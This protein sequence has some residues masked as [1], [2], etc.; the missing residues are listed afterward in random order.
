MGEFFTSSHG[1]RVQ[2]FIAA[3]SAGAQ[4]T[5]VAKIKVGRGRRLR[6]GRQGDFGGTNG[7]II[8]DFN[9][10]NIQI[11]VELYDVSRT[12]IVGG[13]DFFSDEGL[14]G[15]SPLEFIPVI[16]FG[17]VDVSVDDTSG[18]GQGKVFIMR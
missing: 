11:I 16:V 18:V 12:F 5:E 1:A 17:F 13:R 10:I 15:I 14:D 4:R 9:S 2:F 8:V 6:I 3:A 7:L